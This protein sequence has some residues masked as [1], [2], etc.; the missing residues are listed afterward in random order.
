[1][2]T[3]CKYDYYKPNEKYCPR[4]YC[5][6]D[7]KQCIYTKKCLK[8]DK[9][10]PLDGEMWKECYKY[11]MQRKKEIPAGSSLIQVQRPNKKGD[12]IIYVVVN[13]N[14]E[15]I[16]TNFKEIKQEYVYLKEKIDGGY[17][18]SL[19]PFKKEEQK[20]IE[21]KEGFFEIKPEKNE[22]KS[23]ARR[24]YIQKK[25]KEKIEIE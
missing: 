13:D 10:I 3:S 4:L 15:K 23:V 24:K 11:I 5:S 6:I 14:V 2:A 12:I 16:Q 22:S 7:D 18:V 1:M 17:E 19:V 21:V 20:T 8:L 9:F 25:E